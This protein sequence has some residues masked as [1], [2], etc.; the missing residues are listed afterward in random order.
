MIVSSS[1]GKIGL[2]R[3]GADTGSRTWRYA[4]DTALSPANGTTPLTISYRT[5][6]SE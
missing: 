4:T 3:E 1:G 6:P 2:M 5:T